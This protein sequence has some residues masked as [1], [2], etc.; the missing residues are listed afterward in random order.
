MELNPVTPAR[1]YSCLCRVL[2]RTLLTLNDLP[3]PSA[4]DPTCRGPSWI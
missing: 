3:D 2:Q 1:Q 4:D